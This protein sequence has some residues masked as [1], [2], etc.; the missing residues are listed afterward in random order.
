M[1]KKHRGQT[2]SL[3]RLVLAAG[4]FVAVAVGAEVKIGYYGPSDPAHPVGGTIWQGASLGIEEANQEGGY[5]GRPFRLIAR[6][7]EN[8]WSGGASTIVRMIYDERVWAVIGSIDGAT[9]HLAEQVVAKA[10]VPLIDPASTDRSVNAA[11]V[12]WMF[13]VM[14][15]DRRHLQPLAR[16]VEGARYALLAATDHDSR[17]M[18][19]EFVSLVETRG[20]PVRRLDFETRSPRIRD[21]A[22]E[23]AS[24]DVEA[25]VVLAG[26]LD[27]AAVV[28]E[29]RLM[30]PELR[31]YGGPAMGRRAFV[32][33]AG[34]AAEGVH[35]P[36]PIGREAFSSPFA[37]HYSERFG[38]RPDYAA[39]YAYDA[40]N[41][42]VAA[43]RRAGLDR[44]AIRD[45]LEQLA[46]WQGASG[47]ITWDKLRRNSRKTVLGTVRGGRVEVLD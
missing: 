44:T 30:R 24:L 47:E 35:F 3:R 41:L 45:A 11:F 21:I 4:L 18:A 1:T 10:R 31:V 32:E 9:T 19:A 40:T 15:D 20:R 38:H 16:E 33:Q 25:A 34:E 46:P 2:P 29:I 36:L 28:R 26:P 42:L 23:V 17:A 37:R 22:R 12:P 27:S 8:P 7:D 39:I 5:E 14:P 6:W 13:S 43:I